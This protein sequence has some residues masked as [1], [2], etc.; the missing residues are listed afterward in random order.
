MSDSKENSSSSS[1]SSSSKI[2]QVSKYAAIASGIFAA[3][4][5][6]AYLVQS[7]QSRRRQA[8]EVATAL[9]EAATAKATAVYNLE[10]DQGLSEWRQLGAII[11]RPNE[12]WEMLRKF[13]SDGAENLQI[14]SDFDYTMTR[15]RKVWQ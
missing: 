9:A 7:I 4:A 11:P 8:A 6:G 12:C 3:A 5:A 13:K 10:R 1:S 2:H 15:Y 14:I